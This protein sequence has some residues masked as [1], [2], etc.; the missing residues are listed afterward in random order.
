M[1]IAAGDD[2]EV[3]A[4]AGLGEGRCRPAGGLE[5]LEIPVLC[6]AQGVIDDAACALGKRHHRAHAFDI[7]GKAAKEG[8]LGF[9]DQPRRFLDR[10]GERDILAVYGRVGRRQF[11]FE[12]RDRLATAVL[13]DLEARF[14]PFDDE[15]VAKRA[16]ERVDHVL[17]H[18]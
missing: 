2:D 14:A 12:P 11:P 6:F 8:K 15:V 18:S 16:A 13:D 3:G 10:L 1:N 4:V 17:E 9:A 5:D 7:G